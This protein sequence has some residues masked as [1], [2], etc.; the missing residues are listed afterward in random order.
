MEE[1]GWELTMTSN[2][3]KIY[4]QDRDYGY[5]QKP[6]ARK[7]YQTSSSRYA[8]TA[9][10]IEIPEFMKNRAPKSARVRTNQDG[11]VAEFTKNPA[12]TAPHKKEQQHTKTASSSKKSKKHNSIS[13]KTKLFLAALAVTGT[14]AATPSACDYI[15]RFNTATADYDTCGH[16]IEE[17]AEWADIDVEAILLA[18]QI[19]NENTVLDEIVLPESYDPLQEEISAL[20]EKLADDGISDT[21]RTKAE[22][23]LSLLLQ[24]QEEQEKIG[25]TYIDEDGKFIYIVTDELTLVEDIKDAYGIK[26]GVLSEYNDLNYTWGSDEYGGYKDY[27]YSKTTGVRVPV[28]ATGN[29]DE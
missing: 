4:N 14:I 18:N 12:K 25:N 29:F 20:E 19:T 3:I 8:N 21:A 5:N 10:D 11:D 2:N 17:V 27:T 28:D 23:R 9:N 26:D 13:T 7:T 16:T 15:T 6:T 1:T 22:E 24:K